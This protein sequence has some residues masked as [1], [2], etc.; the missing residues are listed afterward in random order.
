MGWATERI[1]LP[2]L[3][4]TTPQL[5]DY[6]MP[7]NGVFHNLIIAK[8]QTRYP[9][10]AS[11]FMHAF[12]GVGQ[13]SFVK[14]AIFVNDD[15]PDLEN[16][17]AL[18]DYILD[19]V[20]IS[21]IIVSEGVCDALDHSSDRFAYGGKLGVD[22]TEDNVNFPQKNILDDE[23]LFS[24]IVEIEPTI[25]EIKQYKT[26]TKTPVCMIAID[27]Q[28]SIKNIYDKLKILK[29]HTK[30]LVFV[31]VQKNDLSNIYMLI[32]RI[33]NNIDA[34]RD[35]FLEKE[36]I[37]ID[38]TNKGKVENFPRRWPDDTDCDREVISNLRKR[39]LLNI[40]DSFLDKYYI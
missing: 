27:K 13:M 38:A 39:G 30:L 14:H 29:E 28:E 7:E 34:S 12:W 6:V 40:D 10:H 35:I 24:K 9:G 19:R 5:I 20:Q 18:S 36:F 31:D 11:Q 3:K 33:V 8:M 16:Y 2:L 25:K 15:A 1:F 21:N 4:T 26:Y 37:G 17:E 23:V 22:C 32:W